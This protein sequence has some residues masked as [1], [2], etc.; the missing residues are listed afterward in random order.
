MLDHQFRR[1]DEF[2]L[3][4]RYFKDID[5]LKSMEDTLMLLRGGPRRN[6]FFNPKTTRACIVTCGGLCPGLNVVIREIVMCLWFNYG[7]R[8]I[9]GII[10]GY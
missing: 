7:V 8:E 3:S 10:G 2:V 1:S 6:I 4:R 5:D 9:Y